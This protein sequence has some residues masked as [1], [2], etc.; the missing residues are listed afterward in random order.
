MSD[1]LFCKIIAGDIPSD[2]VYEDDD[3]YAF[4]DIHPKAPT[5]V[6]VIPKQHVATL[7]D[8]DDPALLGL[9]MNR[10]RTIAD[11]VLN[12]AAGYRIVINVRAGGGQEVFHLHV[13]ILGGKKLPF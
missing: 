4:R 9:L 8:C 10:V 11:D 13:H 1:C 2:K 5:H 6:L 12:L 7:S 3:V